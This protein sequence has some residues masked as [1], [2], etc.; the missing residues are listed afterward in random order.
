MALVD[1]PEHDQRHRQMVELAELPVEIDRRLRRLQ[2]LV[3]T[4]LGERAIGHREIRIEAR[5]ETE[6]T[7]L[8]GGLEPE[9]AGLYGAPRVER[10]I[11]HAE[12][13]IA[14]AG[15][16]QQPRCLGHG[17][18]ALD[19]SQ[20]LRPS[21]PSRA[22]AA[23]I[24]LSECEMASGRRSACERIVCATLCRDA[25][26]AATRAG[27]RSS[28]PWLSPVRN[29]SRPISW[30]IA[31]VRCRRRCRCRLLSTRHS[32][33]RKPSRR[34]SKLRSRSP[35]SQ[36]RP[37]SLRCTRPSRTG[38]SAAR[39]RL[40][41]GVEVHVRLVA[42]TDRAQQIAHVLADAGDGPSIVCATVA[43]NVQGACVVAQGIL[44][45]IDAARPVA[46]GDQVAR[47]ARRGP[48]PG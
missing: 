10:R 35:A 45:G 23:P 16:L 43:Q 34:Q 37:A 20:R 25:R 18:T 11:Q 36:C 32:S 28:A 42:T 48:R 38:S 9:L 7:D 12:I 15:G 8:L 44:I 39:A 4:A 2:A 29:A 27:P 30:K 3:V 47:A 19:A 41:H 31:P 46:R 21:R 33:S 6:V 17:D 24:V 22:S 5:L 14:P 1:L 13:G 26:P 40:Q